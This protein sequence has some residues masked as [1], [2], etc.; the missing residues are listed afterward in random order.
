V[1][2]ET[3]GW[4]IGYFDPC[5][6]TSETFCGAKATMDPTPINRLTQASLQEAFPLPTILVAI[7]FLLSNI[8][9]LL[10]VLHSHQ[11]VKQSRDLWKL[12]NEKKKHKNGFIA[13]AQTMA[14]DSSL[15]EGAPSTNPWDSRKS[16]YSI[17]IAVNDR[18]SN[19]PS[20]HGPP[21][22][23]LDLED[24]PPP[25]PSKMNAQPRA[26]SSHSAMHSFRPHIPNRNTSYRIQ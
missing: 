10:L 20:P 8:T 19:V 18:P 12:V 5:N 7:I 17:I 22:L 1:F 4:D 21:V 24:Q 3:L 25:V 13:Y 2:A 23:H 6:L 15:E 14:V 9:V 11:R 26:S 16:R